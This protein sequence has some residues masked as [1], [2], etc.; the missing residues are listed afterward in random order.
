M[1]PTSLL[2]S[3]IS[4]T[5]DI[6]PREKGANDVLGQNRDSQ[7]TQ[8]PAPRRPDASRRPASLPVAMAD[9]ARSRS[10]AAGS[11]N[12]GAFMRADALANR[13]RILSGGDPSRRSGRQH[14]RD[15]RRGRRRP[16]DA[17]SPLSQR[18]GAQ[19]RAPAAEATASAHR[20]EPPRSNRPGHD[21]PFQAPG[22]LGPRPADRAGGHTGPGR[23]AP[24]PRPG[25]ARGRG[26]SRRRGR[27]RAVRRRHRRLPPAAA[28]GLARVPRTHR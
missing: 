3:Q 1:R 23:G 10:R 26:P 7:H 4:R 6:Y 15:R 14:G 12:A 22:H 24:V 19:R 25:S 2:E 17:V 11:A 21:M 8:T 5:V 20:R 18:A 27:R 16:L 28:R 9:P 13:E